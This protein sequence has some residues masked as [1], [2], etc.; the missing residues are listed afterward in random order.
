MSSTTN[1]QLNVGMLLNNVVLSRSD[2]MGGIM[3]HCIFCGG[4]VSYFNASHPYIQTHMMTHTN[5][6]MSKN[7]IEA[8]T[9]SNGL[10]MEYGTSAMLEKIPQLMYISPIDR[11][12]FAK[13]ISNIV[14]NARNGVLSKFSQF[15]SLST[16]FRESGLLE[17]RLQILDLI[18]D[19]SFE[20]AIS[21]VN[22]LNNENIPCGK[23]YDCGLPTEEIVAK[24]IQ[25]LHVI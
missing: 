3:Y 6:M 22:G 16:I 1:K 15:A 19:A 21:F 25:N 11:A 24:H 20:C 2:R 5:G 7:M 4:F 18:Q 17:Y 23:I 14:E 13:G 12:K 8:G 10:M 9:D